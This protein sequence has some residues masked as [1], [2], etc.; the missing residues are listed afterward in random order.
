MKKTL[1]SLSIFG[2]AAAGT[3]SAQ[4]YLSENFNSVTAPALPTNWASSPTSVWKTGDPDALVPNSSAGLGYTLT[5]TAHSQVLGIDGSVAS[6]NGA[7][8]SLP[9]VTL[10]S[11]A[12]SAA[13][14]FD[15]AYFKVYL[16]ASPTTKEA[17]LVV[18]STDGGTTWTNVD[19]ISANTSY[20]WETKSISLA[21]YA[22]QSN[23]KFG[24]KYYNSGGALVGA[25]LD[26]VRIFMGAD[27]TMTSA[28]GGTYKSFL[29]KSYQQTGT[30]SDITGVITNTGTTTITSYVVKYKVASGAVLSSSVTNVS[31]A[32]LATNSFTHASAFTAASVTEYPIKVWVELTSDADNSNDTASITVVGV[33]SVPTKKLV[34]EEGTGT[35]CGWCPRGAVYMEQFAEDHPGA[36]AQIA[37]HNSDP[38][39]VTAYDNYM[40]TYNGGGFPNLVVDRATELDPSYIEAAYTAYGSYFG[41]AELTLGTPT[42]SGTSV[43]IPLTIVPSVDITTPKF[44]LVVTEDNVTGTGTSWLQHN[45]Y[46]GGTYGTMGGWESLGS[47]V[48]GVSFEFVARSISPS[49]GGATGTGL[50]TTLT[51]G[52][53]YTTSL[54]TTLDTSWKTADLKYIAMMIDNSTTSILNSAI[55]S[56]ATSMSNVVAGIN[57]ANVYP[58]PTIDKAYLEVDMKEASNV[59]LTVTDLLG[60]TLSSMDKALRSGTNILEINTNNLTAG[61]YLVNLN[62]EK[63]KVSFKLNVQ[64]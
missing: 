49:P 31:I 4:T 45:Y 11:T 60:R 48:S 52:Q 54:T 19:S 13:L 2:F 3:V 18:V 15:A 32:P 44:A 26:N 61:V 6:N 63:G 30:Q 41:F 37:V 56:S 40:T 50:P 12:T 5:S 23:L 10:P 34:F 43:T 7:I 47:T 64:K 20:Y 17:F 14:I 62:T 27:A 55:Y 24:F 39:E 16:T 35:W 58:N 38:M 9:S 36:A 53:T 22:G 42:V 28:S 29:G 46:A 51:A 33:S 1:L 21:S 25:A 57:K 8:V 59:N